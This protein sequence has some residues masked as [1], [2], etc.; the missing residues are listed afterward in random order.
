MEN[1]E[2]KLVRLEEL[3]SKNYNQLNENDLY[4]WQYISAHR[5]ECE[6]LSIDELASRCHASRTTVLRFS[7]RLGLKG[8]AE[9]KVYLRIDNQN[10]QY[11]QTGVELVYE[12][13]QAYIK[14]IK[15][16]DM[17]RVIEMIA[18]A[19]NTYAY[20]TGSIQNNVAAELKRSFLIVNKMFFTIQ[21]T[22]ETNAFEEII[23]DQDLIVIIS[24]S[25]ENEQAVQ[26]AKK[27]K[28]KGV[29]IIS[30]TATQNNTLSHLADEALYVDVPNI[31]NPLGP[32]YE[33]LVN[34]FI[35]IDFILVKYMD[36]YERKMNSD[37]R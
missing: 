37:I 24:Y 23:T 17:T 27:L 8:Y 11:K 9:L 20:G 2:G 26:F 21:S 18:N 12:R 7:K 10:Y 22:N 19:K 15:K 16:R 35:L 6:K 14:D 1:Q 36:Y 4:I 33:G 28:M 3:I 34:Y 29:P 30:I 25:G 31:V 13:Y 5:K 32:R